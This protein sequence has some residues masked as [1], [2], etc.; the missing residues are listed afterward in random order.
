MSKKVFVIYPKI[1]EKQAEMMFAQTS[2]EGKELDFAQV[3]KD[4][5]QIISMFGELEKTTS[6]YYVDEAKLTIGVITG[7]SGSVRAGISTN[8]LSIFKGQINADV[9]EK[10][11][12]NNL[13]E[14]TIK[15]KA[16]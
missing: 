7:E 8:F 15:R 3:Q 16:T 5:K 6:K 14:I 11:S 1:K 9:A 10:F 2:M 12:G 13:I 4:L